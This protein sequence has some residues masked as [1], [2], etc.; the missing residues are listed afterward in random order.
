MRKASVIPSGVTLDGEIEGQG[1]LVI[2]GH[3][4]GPI[5]LDGALVIEGS[6]RVDGPVRAR[7]I[8]IHGTLLGDAFAGRLVRVD[9][10]GKV[11]GDLS[12][13]RVNVVPGARFRGRIHTTDELSAARESVQVPSAETSDLK[14]EA[15]RA[16]VELPRASEVA[17]ITE[18]HE[19]D[20]DLTTTSEISLDQKDRQVV[21]APNPMAPAAVRF[22]MPVVRRTR[23]R[24]R[25]RGD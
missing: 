22:A 9:A 2:F 25:R 16:R 18:P 5:R 7:S 20:N 12:A 21:T 8:S 13:P 3:V 11:V 23:G 17:S 10:K 6:G 4:T 15:P 14:R 19:E 24:R 1:D